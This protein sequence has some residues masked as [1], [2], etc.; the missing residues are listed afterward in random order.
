MMNEQH[1]AL[2]DNL[3]LLALGELDA[4]QSAELHAHLEV[5]E[6]CRREF[7]EISGGVALLALTASGPAA[8]QRSRDRV[9]REIGVS[10]PPPVAANTSHQHAAERDEEPVMIEHPVRRAAQFTSMRRPWWSFAPAFAAVLVAIFAILLWTNNA[11]LRRQLETAQRVATEAQKQLADAELSLSNAQLVNQA[12]TDPQVQKVTLVSAQEKPQPGARAMYMP[13][14]K[15]L[16]LIAQNLAPV[17]SDKAY[18]LW[19]LPKNGGAP[20]AAGTFRPDAHGSAMMT[21]TNLGSTPDAKGFAITVERA[22]GSA[23]PTSPILLAGE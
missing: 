11:S 9:L 16:V 3:S 17:P 8:P 21:Q 14:R 1:L 20:V 4:A 10:A 23:A 18:E 6:F 7:E 5:C 22:E 2:M 19:I 15:A 12:M 13:E